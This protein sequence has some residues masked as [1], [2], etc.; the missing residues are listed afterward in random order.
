MAKIRVS[1]I[2]DAEPATVW[3]VVEPIER[4]VDWMADA[5]AIRF[6]SES[7]RGVGTTFECD[8]KV[9]P[10]KLTDLMEITEWVEGEVMG[11]RHTGIVTGSGRFTLHPAGPGRT[12]FRWEEELIFPFWMGGPLRDPVG[13]RILE[14][15][16][17]RNLKKLK[18]IAEAH[19]P[20]A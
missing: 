17:R 16:W 3:E 14:W 6:T 7:T 13:G 20:A 2:I 1:T 19:V 4:H 9:G 15:I 11:V 5:E 10:A 18:A 8:T 12:E